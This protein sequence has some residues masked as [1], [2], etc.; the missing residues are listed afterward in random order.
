MSV[1][2]YETGADFIPEF[3]TSTARDLIIAP[4]K[5]RVLEAYHRAIN[6]QPVR[7]RLSAQLFE[8]RNRTVIKPLNEQR[9]SFSDVFVDMD[10]H[11]TLFNP[12]N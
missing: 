8:L 9:A 2:G 10:D 12:R 11:E 4:G 6:G 5:L 7:G 1:S 3:L